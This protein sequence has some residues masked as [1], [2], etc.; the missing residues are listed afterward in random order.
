MVYKENSKEVDIRKLISTEEKFKDNK[1]N[2]TKQ[3]CKKSKAD[4]EQMDY[5]NFDFTKLYANADAFV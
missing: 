5:T 1:Y 4:F 2:S 3:N